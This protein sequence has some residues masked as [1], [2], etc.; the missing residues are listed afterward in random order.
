[1]SWHLSLHGPRLVVA[2]TCVLAGLARGPAAWADGDPFGP[3]VSMHAMDTA[4]GV[5]SDGAPASSTFV[6]D[7]AREV[8]WV[9]TSTEEL[10]VT[11]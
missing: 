11:L 6:V 2:A 7:D 5:V 10:D 3:E 8:T 1:M 9:L 4:G